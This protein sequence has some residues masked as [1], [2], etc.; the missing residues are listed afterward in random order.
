[1]S[2]MPLILP[3]H[4]FKIIADC[5]QSFLVMYRIFMTTIKLSFFLFK[6]RESLSLVDTNFLIVINCSFLFDIILSF[7]TGYYEKGIII[8]DRKKIALNYF[9]SKLINYI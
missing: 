5:W 9:K 2:C 3:N 7:N 6:Q 8:F 4:K 1:M